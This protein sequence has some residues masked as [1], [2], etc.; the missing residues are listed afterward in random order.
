MPLFSEFS[1]DFGIGHDGYIQLARSLANGDGYVFERPNELKPSVYWCYSYS[2]ADIGLVIF[3]H[4]SY[5]PYVFRL[6]M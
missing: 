5:L 3:H 6:I 2:R 1:K 4:P